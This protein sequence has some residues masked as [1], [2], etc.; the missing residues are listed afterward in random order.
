MIQCTKPQLLFFLFQ[1]T[2]A[3]LV[4]YKTLLGKR[5][6]LSGITKSS[7]LVVQFALVSFKFVTLLLKVKKQDL[8]CASTIGNYYMM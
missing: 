6:D 4:Q 2:Q 7:L 1:K 8:V 3:L 5:K